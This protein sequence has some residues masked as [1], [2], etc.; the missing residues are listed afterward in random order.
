MSA[1]ASLNKI[2]REN[3][4]KIL[5]EGQTVHAITTPFVKPG[6]FKD[7]PKFHNMVNEFVSSAD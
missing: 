6:M 1:A 3:A 2:P 4:E 7:F 5:T